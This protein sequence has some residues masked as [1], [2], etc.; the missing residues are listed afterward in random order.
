MSNNELRLYDPKMD[1]IFQKPYTDIDEWK[2]GTV[3]YRYIHGGF[4]GTETRFALFLPEEKDYQERFIHFMC[5]VPGNENAAMAG[6]AEKITFAITNGAYLVESNMGVSASFGAMADPTIIYKASAAVAEYAR[7]LVVSIYGGGRPYGVIYGGSGGGFKTISCIENTKAWDG[8]V[9]FVIGSSMSVPYAITAATHAARVLRNKLSQIADA[10]DSG[11]SK[12]PY[13]FLNN[14]EAEA[15]KEITRFGFPLRS[16]FS[17]KPGAD[18]SLPVLAPIVKSV[19]PDYFIDF[20]EQPGYLGYDK[21]SSAVRDRL[22]H[23]T[24]IRSLTIPPV[25]NKQNWEDRTGVDDAWQRLTR[26]NE[27]ERVHVFLNKMPPDDAFTHGVELKLLSG[28][29]EGRVFP[30]EK[31]ESDRLILGGTLGADDFIEDFAKVK[32]GDVVLL[33]NSDYIAIQTYHRHQVP[34]E[35]F[36]IYD[37]YRDEK[38]EPIYP[39]R[40]ILL[41]PGIANGGAGSLQSGKIQCKTIVIAA[42]LDGNLPW[43]AHWYREKVNEYL[44]QNLDD[45]FRLW[46]VDNAVHSDESISGD[47]LNISGY[48]GV[49]HQ[50]ILDVLDWAQYGIAPAGS[51]NY[52][53]SDGQIIVAEKADERLGIQPVITLTANGNE[54][55]KIKTGETVE[56]NA[57]ID[58]PPNSGSVTK[59]EWSFEH[60]TDFPYHSNGIEY[61]ESRCT[62][63]ASHTYTKDGT[64]FA[65]VKVSVNRN[66]DEKNNFT[67]VKNLSRAR[68][69]VAN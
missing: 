18:G 41:G 64:Y 5:P 42:L 53:V 24:E 62:A 52:K 38:G 65:V 61:T 2:Q 12:D 32:P 8:A 31:V 44:E 46:Y 63:K 58:L 35:G 56:F 11:G 27:E 50:A 67:Q 36:E 30:V 57:I 21:N 16:W 43:K 7:E 66:G 19:D 4:E 23:K 39:Q 13:E 22:Q 20:W 49:M 34:S 55:I 59:V 45:N 37:Q 54:Y 48:F 14:E 15:L 3:R 1:P 69:I 60:E 28:A 33:D 10:M 29:M 47:E 25:T 68:I 51:T 26:K 17:V 40:A 6:A 9:P